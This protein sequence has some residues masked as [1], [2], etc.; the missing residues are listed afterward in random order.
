MEE[1]LSVFHHI[2]HKGGKHEVHHCGGAHFKI[3]SKLNYLITHC[4]CGEHSIN[5]KR[6]IGHVSSKNLKPVEIE[7]KFTEKCLYGGW[8]VESGVPKKLCDKKSKK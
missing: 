6:A 7:I 3:D 5:K 1:V 4:R 8:H 2:H